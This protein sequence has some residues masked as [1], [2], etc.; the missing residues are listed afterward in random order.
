[1]KPVYEQVAKLISLNKLDMAVAAVDGT[2]A[3][4]LRDLYKIETYPTLKLFK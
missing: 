1:M 4:V 3:P 2:T